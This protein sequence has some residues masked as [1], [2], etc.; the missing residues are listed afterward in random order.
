MLKR[1]VGDI[2]PEFFLDEPADKDNET[3]ANVARFAAMGKGK[4]KELATRDYELKMAA[5]FKECY[6]VL[7][8]DSVM[9]VMFNH[10]KVEAWD[11]LATAL[12]DAGF[13]IKSSWPVHTESEHS[14]HQ[15]KKN[16]AA[17]TILLAC[18]K[19]EKSS[20][21]VWWDDISNRVGVVAREKAEEFLEA[22]ITEGR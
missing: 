1:T 18:R 12:I 20:E 5:I 16:S 10:K 8:P 7:R 4:K 14:L 21:P 9:T 11:S 15:A 13:S 3:V 2:Y 17:S 19:R 6:R 22:G